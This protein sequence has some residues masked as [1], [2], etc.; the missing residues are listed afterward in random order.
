MPDRQQLLTPN[1]FDNKY[2]S[3]SSSSNNGLAGFK[4]RTS[5]SFSSATLKPSM[6]FFPLETA[7]PFASHSQVPHGTLSHQSSHQKSHS[8]T[9]NHLNLS[10]SYELPPYEGRHNTRG[11]K[12]QSSARYSHNLSAFSGDNQFDKTSARCGLSSFKQQQ[13]D[14]RKQLSAAAAMTA[15]IEYKQVDFIKT[16]ALNKCTKERTSGRGSDFNPLFGSSLQRRN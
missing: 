15:G 16:E 6:N 8:L 11:N 13:V 2:S 9:E 10:S 3:S 5:T 14:N 1:L 4:T 12:Q 7:L